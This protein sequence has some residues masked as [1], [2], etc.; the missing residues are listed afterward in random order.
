MTSTT[1]FDEHNDLLFLSY[2]INT[3]ISFLLNTLAI[4]LILFKSPCEM[5]TYRWHLLN[6]QVFKIKLLFFEIYVL[7]IKLKT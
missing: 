2:Q 4:Y 3:P 5:K 7:S 1:I 6:Y